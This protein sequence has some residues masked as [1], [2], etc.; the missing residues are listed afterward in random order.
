MKNTRGKD[1]TIIGSEVVKIENDFAS[2][3]AELYKTRFASDGYN[4]TLHNRFVGKGFSRF[5]YYDIILSE[6]L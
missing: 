4:T 2:D 3:L 5:Y 6:N 1:S